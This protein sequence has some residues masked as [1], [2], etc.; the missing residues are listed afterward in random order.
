MLMVFAGLLA[1]M[2]SLVGVQQRIDFE[3]QPKNQFE[4]VQAHAGGG[5]GTDPVAIKPMAEFKYANIA[6]QQ[7]DYSCGSGALVTVLNYHLGLPITEQ[8]AMEGM[9]AKGEKDKI[10]ERRGF[11]LLDM[12]LYVTSIGVRGAGYKGD[13][14]DLLKLD[15]PAI[16]PINYGGFMHFV[17]LRGMRDGKAYIA[18]PSAGHFVLS[19][20]EFMRWWDSSRT[21]FIVYPAKDKPAIAKLALS[22]AEL[23]VMDSDRVR[24]PTV[25]D[26]TMALQRAVDAHAGGMWLRR[27]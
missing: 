18:D 11:S 3:P 23:G 22:D 12:K 6:R 1:A 14:N 15:Q 2:I 10:I 27:R 16:V 5:S 20:D 19:S 13:L 24:D 7:Y 21:L 17:V 9:L 25:F 26:R 8:Q 4:I